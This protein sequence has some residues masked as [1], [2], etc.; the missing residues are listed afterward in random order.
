MVS[1]SGRGGIGCEGGGRQLLPKELQ[2][3]K[4]RAGLRLNRA[5]NMLH[6]GLIGLGWLAM[7]GVETGETWGWTESF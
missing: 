2:R 7:V 5:E 6:M 3:R 1:Y 4:E